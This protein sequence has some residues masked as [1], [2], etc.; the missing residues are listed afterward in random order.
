MKDGDSSELIAVIKA[1]AKLFPP[2]SDID[3]GCAAIANGVLRWFRD[4]AAHYEAEIGDLKIELARLA[5]ER[6]QWE[7]AATKCKEEHLTLLWRLR[8]LTSS[9]P[10]ESETPR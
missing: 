9:G 4:F 1:Q 3:E 7:R 5:Q 2:G 6:D 10:A 8:S